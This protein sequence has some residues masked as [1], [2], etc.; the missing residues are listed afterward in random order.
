MKHRNL[1]IIFIVILAG[2]FEGCGN[3]ADQCKPLTIISGQQSEDS[4][5]IDEN[6]DQVQKFAAE[7]LQ[8]YLKQ[9]T[10]I[11]LQIMNNTEKHKFI[12]VGRDEFT[13]IQTS[14]K[15]SIWND[16]YFIRFRGKNI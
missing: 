13:D 10:G 4:I 16:E 3:S 1:Q 2:Y 14:D 12:S 6:A 7:E 15:D 11:E 8:K 5:W 9:M